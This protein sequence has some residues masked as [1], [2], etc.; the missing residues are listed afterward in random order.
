MSATLWATLP[1]LALSVSGTPSLSYMKYPDLVQCIPSPLA[2]TL[3]SRLGSIGCDLAKLGARTALHIALPLR[4]AGA[5]NL[6]DSESSDDGVVLSARKE[7]VRDALHTRHYIAPH[8]YHEDPSAG[9][10]PAGYRPV[11]IADILCYSNQQAPTGTSLY[12]DSGLQLVEIAGSEYQAAGAAVTKGP[13]RILVRVAGP[14][15]SYGVEMYGATI[16]AAIASDGDTH[17][18]DNIAATKCAH[19]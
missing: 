19:R 14:Q 5:P 17:Y 2:N 9:T 4:P 6:I 10:V 3:R 1:L 8:R 15:Q 18:F 13:L 16:G 11:P 12:S 7:Q